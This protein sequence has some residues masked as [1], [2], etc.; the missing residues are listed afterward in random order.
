MTNNELSR[1]IINTLHQQPN[2]SLK[3]S[4]LTERLNI[5]KKRVALNLFY[6]ES[7]GIIE[8]RSVYSSDS[9]FPEIYFVSLKPKGVFL[10]E[11]PD[12]LDTIFP[13]DMEYSLLNINPIIDNLM[14]ALKTWAGN[15]S[16]RLTLYKKLTEVFEDPLF[17][18][19]IEEHYSG[20]QQR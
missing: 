9:L 15:D 8:L 6:L 7:N 14:K 13:L 16:K 19:F 18:D 5:D 17:N 2:G 10:A 1:N 4:Q 11:N 20:R 12:K 3:F